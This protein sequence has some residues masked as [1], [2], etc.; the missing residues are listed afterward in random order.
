MAVG[1]IAVMGVLLAACGSGGSDTTISTETT[2]AA[3]SSLAAETT[4]AAET[5]AVVETSVAADT[6]PPVETS[7]AS[8]VAAE[9]T[10]APATTS[11]SATVPATV[12]ASTAVMSLR[13]QASELAGSLG[14]ADMGAGNL[15]QPLVVRNIGQRTC[16]LDGYPGVSLLDSAGVQIGEPAERAQGVRATISLPPGAS[17]S[18]LLHTTNGPIGDPCLAPSVSLKMFPPNETEPLIFPVVFTSCGGMSVR[19]FVAGIL[20]Q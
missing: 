17:A 10:A 4:V 7:A 13:C 18:A 9:T 11:A 14:A 12:V 3:E 8:T 19:P 20:G 15:Y 6:T 5:T 2:I 1:G 16:T